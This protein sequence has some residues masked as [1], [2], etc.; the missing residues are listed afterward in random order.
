ME[1][2]VIGVVLGLM[3]GFVPGPFSAYVA[4]TAMDKGL[5]AGLRVALT[6][7]L[8]ETPVM[9]ATA[10][11]LNEVSD[12]VLRWVGIGGGVAILILAVQT[13]SRADRTRA[14]NAADGSLEVAR[15]VREDIVKL[16]ITGLLSPSPWIFWTAVASPLLLAAWQL[17]PVYG[18]AFV[19]VFFASFVGSQMLIALGAVKGIRKLDPRWQAWLMRGV[20]AVLVVAGLALVWQSYTGNFRDLIRAPQAVREAIR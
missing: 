2:L 19:G 5:T 11:L 16:T 20:A 13:F 8:V 6:P 17:S 4:A 12:A 1:F 3:A 18:T 9:L 15:D 7:L 14:W 10:L